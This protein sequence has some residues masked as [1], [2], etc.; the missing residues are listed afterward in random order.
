MISGL[1]NALVD[2]LVRIPDDEVLQRLDLR[3]GTMHLVD[4]AR[5]VT[6]L[7]EVEALGV[8]FAPGGSCANTIVTAAVLGAEADLHANVGPDRFGEIYVE[9]AASVLGE[10][11]VRRGDDGPTGKCLSLISEADAER[12][13]LTDL[14]CAMELPLAAL[15]RESLRAASIFHCTGYLFT[16]GPI[17]AVA[18]EALAEAAAHDTRVSFDV[19]DPWVIEAHRER[20]APVVHEQAHVVFLNAEEAKLWGGVDDP[21]AAAEALAQRVPVVAL[22]LGSKGSLVLW[23]GQRHEVQATR[24]AALDTTGAGDAYAGGFLYGLDRGLAPPRCAEIASRIAALTVSQVGAV[25]RD[26]DLARTAIG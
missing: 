22:K 14:G 23:D 15:S 7:R 9:G 26:Q 3:R 10:H 21:V 18:D 13:M 5:W 16:G 24:V 6:A 20:L 25:V 4:D 11:H 1:G 2:A 19:A 12:T 8:E 17:G